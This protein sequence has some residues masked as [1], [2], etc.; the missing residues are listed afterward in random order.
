M[1]FTDLL[2]RTAGE[3]GLSLRIVALRAGMDPSY[4]NRVRHGH[5]TMPADRIESL[6]NALGISG[7]ERVAFIE[8]AHLAIVPDFVMNLVE[9]LRD[10][11]RA[12]RAMNQDLMRRLGQ[13]K[14][15]RSTKCSPG[16]AN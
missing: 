16:G 4:L 10:D 3:R 9:L 8:Q 15:P 11:I 7:D 6:A 14:S 13:I 5:R 12:C 1:N 2:A